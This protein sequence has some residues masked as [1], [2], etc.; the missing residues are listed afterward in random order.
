MS[1]SFSP[2]QQ[3]YTLSAHDALEI[4]VTPLAKDPTRREW[5]WFVAWT[6]VAALT[7]CAVAW[8]ALVLII[9]GVIL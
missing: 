5:D 7:F 1:A 8:I 6:W 4:G 9:A 2:T 3:S